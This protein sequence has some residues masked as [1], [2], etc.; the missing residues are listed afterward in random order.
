MRVDEN[1]YCY[2]KSQLSQYIY[3]IIQYRFTDQQ[4]LMQYKEHIGI[5]NWKHYF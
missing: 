5:Y 1:I 3:N 4:L 2:L